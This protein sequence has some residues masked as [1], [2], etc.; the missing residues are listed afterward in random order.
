MRARFFALGTTFALSAAAQPAP[1]PRPM[2]PPP[3]YADWHLAVQTESAFGVVPDTFYNHLAGARIDRRFAP[4]VSLGLYL[5]YANLKGKDG[6]AHN[7]LGYAMLEYRPELASGVGL[8]LRFAPG[9]LPKNGPVLRASAGLSFVLSDGVDL[10]FDLITP[11]VWVT[12]D[13]AV[14]SFDVAAELGFDL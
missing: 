10:V 4:D 14:L 11:T 3:S 5:G 8:P 13:Q 1:P 9:Y 6:R 7:G 12:H 2:P